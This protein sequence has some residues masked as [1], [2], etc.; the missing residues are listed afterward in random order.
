VGVPDNTPLALRRKPGMDPFSPHANG[1]R[2]LLLVNWNG[3]YAAPTVAVGGGV[4]LIAG[5][6]GLLTTMV[7]GAEPV[8]AGVA[9]SVAVAVN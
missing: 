1:G 3:E 4:L 9:L 2:P 8:P 5:G 6:A 7:N